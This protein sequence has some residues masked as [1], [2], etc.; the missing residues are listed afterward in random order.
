MTW[1]S[2]SRC[3][4][5]NSQ[6]G[7][8]KVIRKKREKIWSFM[9]EEMP[10]FMFTLCTLL[11]D[12][13]FKYRVFIKKMCF[14]KIL[15]NIPDSGLSWFPLGVS[16]CTQWQVKHQRCSSRTCRVQKNRNIL[17][18]NTIFNEHPVYHEK[19]HQGQN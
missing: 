18:K 13:K 10:E 6:M 5:A 14:S 12:S 17:W 11:I 4:A 15:T 3:P 7:E 9:Y 16:E 8:L 2:L 1:R 19:E